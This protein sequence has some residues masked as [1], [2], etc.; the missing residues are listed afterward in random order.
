MFRLSRRYNIHP[1]LLTIFFVL[2]LIAASAAFGYLVE[3]LRL[4][5]SFDRVVYN[6]FQFTWHPAWLD[7]IITPFNFNFIPLGGPQF[8]NFLVVII[9]LIII[10]TSILNQVTVT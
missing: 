10:V 3:N 2:L 6:F 5:Q 4:F 8:L 1:I 7:V 9:V